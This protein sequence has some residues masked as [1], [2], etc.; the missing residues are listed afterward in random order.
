VS[1]PRKNGQAV[2][3]TVFE[4]SHPGRSGYRLPALDVPPAD[5][6]EVLGAS[7]LRSTPPELPELSEPEVVDTSLDWRR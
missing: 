1:D 2:E 6:A 5:L 4:L 3:P 7:N